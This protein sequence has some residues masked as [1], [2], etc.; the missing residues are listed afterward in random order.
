MQPGPKYDW[1]EEGERLNAQNEKESPK[2]QKPR[3]RPKANTQQK[4]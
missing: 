1:K 3:P 2:S 4:E